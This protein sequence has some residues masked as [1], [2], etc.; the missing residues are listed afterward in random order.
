MQVLLGKTAGKL[1]KHLVCTF[2]FGQQATGAI[3]LGLHHGVGALI[4]I[5]NDRHNGTRIHPVHKILNTA[6]NNG[7]GLN[8]G[9]LARITGHLHI[10]AQIVDRVQIDVIQ[11][12]HFGLDIARHRQ[13]Y[14][15]HGHMAPRPG[16]FL[17]QSQTQYGQGTGRTGDHNIKFGQA[18][19]QVGQLHGFTIEPGGER[20]RTL[21][22][23]IGYDHTG[24][25]LR[26]KMGGTQLDHFTGPNK[27]HPGFGQI[28][29]HPLGQPH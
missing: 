17:H 12:R 1:L 13:V 19:G 23:A 21:T 26:G 20:F 6:I 29:K 8:H 22:R 11:L 28:A 2:A 24:G 4:Q 18:L 16:R 3:Q 9:C 14:H 10:T 27:Q 7:F 15:D 25:L 5:A